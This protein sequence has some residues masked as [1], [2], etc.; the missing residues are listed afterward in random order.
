VIVSSRS[1]EE[2][3]TK[4]MQLGAKDYL[5]KPAVGSQIAKALERIGLVQGAQ[6]E[7]ENR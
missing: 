5:L 2:F 1:E 6:A 3:R 4:A 7:G